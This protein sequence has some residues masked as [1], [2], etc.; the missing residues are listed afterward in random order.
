MSLISRLSSRPTEPFLERLAGVW[1][2]YRADELKLAG[3]GVGLGM[4]GGLM[5]VLLPNPLIGFAVVLGLVAGLIMLARPVFSLGCA[6]AIVCL[7]P[8]GV[9]PVRVGLTFTFLEATLLLLLVGWLLR[10]SVGQRSRT[11]ETFI[12]GPFDWAILL[13]LGLSVFALMLH[14]QTSSSS[15]VLHNYFKFLLAVLSFWPVINLIK[16][17]ALLDRMLRVI[18]LCGGLAAFI[19]LGLFALN[20]TVQRQLLLLLGPLGYP[21]D[22]RVLRY[23]EDD[24]AQAQ[25]ITGTSVDP[26]SYA[27]MLVVIIA[28]LLTQLLSPKPL[29]KRWLLLAMLAGSVLA[30]ALTYGRGAQL[31]AVVLALFISFKYRKLWLYGLPFVGLAVVVLPNTFIWTRLLAGFAGEDQSTKLHLAEFQNAFAIIGRYPW[32]GIG[33]GP[34]PDPDLQAGVS[35]IYFTVAER[36]GLIGLAAFMVVVVFFLL[37][38]GGNYWRQTTEKQKANLLGLLMGVI[39]ALTVGVLDHYFFNIEFPHMAALLWLFIA[40]AVAQV[41]ISRTLASSLQSE[42]QAKIKR[43]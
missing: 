36:M 2:Q 23:H 1:P 30:L 12:A 32:F 11:E 6:V 4:A 8:F 5:A 22:D 35:S 21:T 37:Y 24:P 39:G 31:G 29:L 13:L 10:L 27:G 34:A 26:N 15:D 28:L 18:M 14:W 17:Q 7:L 25:R 19:G 9:I 3:I 40:L 38:V 43:V 42:A 16:T 41:K 20:Q 33:Y